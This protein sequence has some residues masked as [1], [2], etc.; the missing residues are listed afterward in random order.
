ME[1]KFLVV[2]S[3]WRRC[4][5]VF[6]R[7]VRRRLRNEQKKVL[8]ETVVS[9]F[10]LNSSF[11]LSFPFIHPIHSQKI[12]QSFEKTPTLHVVFGLSEIKD[13]DQS[14]FMVY[15]LKKT[16]M[17]IGMDHMNICECVENI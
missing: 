3:N 11:F 8:I 7:V 14:G 1:M 15:F 6:S 13:V 16:V 10:V 9:Y 4:G 17:P 2:V 12:E 5:G